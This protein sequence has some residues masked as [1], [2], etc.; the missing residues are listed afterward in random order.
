MTPFFNSRVQAVNL[1]PGS[2]SIKSW[3]AP[4]EQVR[5]HIAAEQRKRKA[6]GKPT[7]DSEI[8]LTPGK[9]AAG[10]G[11]VMTIPGAAECS[12]RRAI[13]TPGST[14]PLLRSCRLV[15]TN[16]IVDAHNFPDSSRATPRL[17]PKPDALLV[18][19]PYC[20]DKSWPTRYLEMR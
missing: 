6:W 1:F 7:S 5:I 13:L 8:G 11:L 18:L 10:I 12:L 15:V 9:R 16:E 19:A 20:Q 17:L 4:K 14:L 2:K 3:A